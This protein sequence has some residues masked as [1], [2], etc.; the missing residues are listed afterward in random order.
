VYW[1]VRTGPFTD[2]ES[3]SKGGNLYPWLYAGLI[4]RMQRRREC[5]E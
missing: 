5:D 3:P 2:L 4:P 1:F